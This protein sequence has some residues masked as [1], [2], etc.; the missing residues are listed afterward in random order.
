M[1]KLIIMQKE[2]FEDDTKRK[3]VCVEQTSH[4]KIK[5]ISKETGYTLFEVT[6]LLLRFALKNVEISN[7]QTV[8]EEEIKEEEVEEVE[9]EDNQL[10]G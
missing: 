1:N 8:F 10:W 7:K 3:M 9:Q 4:N 2:I 5:E 6:S